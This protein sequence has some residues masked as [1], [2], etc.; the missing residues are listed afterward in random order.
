MLKGFILIKNKLNL[1]IFVIL[2]RK[3]KSTREVKL[4]WVLDFDDQG[5]IFLIDF[6]HEKPTYLETKEEDFFTL[7]LDKKIGEIKTKTRPEQRKF[8]YQKIKNYG[9]KC[10][11]CS[12]EHPRLLDAVHIRGKEEK[13]SD[14][15]R[16]GL[17]LCRNHHAAFD[18]HLFRI[19][20]KDFSIKYD[21]DNIKIEEKFLKNKKG[22]VPHKDALM[23]RWKRS[24]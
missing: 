15:W 9:Y 2:E 21:E 18:N 6:N 1:P 23:W 14:D 11:V 20:P 12:I 17:F 8:R 16:N 5:E 19:N 7:T 22:K 3:K 10:S 4:G 13:G 24:K